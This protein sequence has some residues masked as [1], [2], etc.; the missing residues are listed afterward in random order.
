MFVIYQ[1]GPDP[2]PPALDP[3]KVKPTF[4]VYR[5]RPRYSAIWLPVVL[6]IWVIPYTLIKVFNYSKEQP[7]LYSTSFNGSTYRRKQSS[8][9]PIKSRDTPL[10][11]DN[12]TKFWGNVQAEEYKIT[13]Y[14][15]LWEEIH[16]QI[17]GDSLYPETYDADKVLYALRNSKIIGADLFKVH[18]S[19][20]LKLT[21]E[22]GQQ[23]I[24][25]VKLM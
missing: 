1:G 8:Y 25:K 4:Y 5:R 10:T 23:A 19:M 12:L 7:A 22:G 20:K 21:L 24:F 11:N 16:A 17:H 6:L 18:T 3:P 14:T 2:P 15:E 13:N 9:Y